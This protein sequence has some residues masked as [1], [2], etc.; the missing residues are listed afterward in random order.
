MRGTTDRLIPEVWGE[1]LATSLGTDLVP[2][3]EKGHL[4]VLSDWSLVLEPF[5][6]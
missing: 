6:G 4:F 3:S 5:A 1:R 2:V